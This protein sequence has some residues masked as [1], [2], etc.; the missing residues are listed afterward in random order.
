MHYLA[1]TTIIPVP[2]VL[3]AGI[4][5]C[6]LYIVAEHIESTFLTNR[7]DPNI[8]TRTDLERAYD[9]MAQVMLELSKLTFP[10][11]DAVVQTADGKWLIQS[12]KQRQALSS[13]MADILRP[14]SL[15]SIFSTKTF[16][17]ASECFTDLATQHFRRLYHQR[18]NG[19]I[20]DNH[21]WKERYIARSITTEP[22]PF[23]LSSATSA[24]RMSWYY[25]TIPAPRTPIT[26]ITGSHRRL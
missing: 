7:L 5:D 12:T 16:A 1:R 10:K 4:W 14:N 26:P 11:I 3:G 24:R 25:R 9:C 13:T 8:I 17:T 22:D 2:T 21:S 6:G 19:F 15:I 23:R 20:P 18:N